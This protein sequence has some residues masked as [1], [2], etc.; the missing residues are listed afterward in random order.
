MVTESNTAC[1]IVPIFWCYWQT[2]YD[3]C[4]CSTCGYGGVSSWKIDSFDDEIGTWKNPHWS[5]YPRLQTVSNLTIF[6][7]FNSTVWT[8][9]ATPVND[10]IVMGWPA[11]PE[12][13]T[14][15]ALSL[16]VY[17]PN[18]ETYYSQFLITNNQIYTR[19]KEDHIA[20]QKLPSENGLPCVGRI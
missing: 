1:D 5:I 4:S 20:W 2:E 10:A 15:A 14:I 13:F 19:R 6:S 11:A 8:K 17:T 3:A 9:L 7:L 16:K 18:D 12:R